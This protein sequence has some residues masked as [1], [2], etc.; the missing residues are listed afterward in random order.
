MWPYPMN[1]SANEYFS[2]PPLVQMKLLKSFV[3]F[4][5]QPFRLFETTVFVFFFPFQ[6]SH[7]AL[8]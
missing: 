1:F 2:H 6:E 3:Y 8:Q 4:L 7:N 5:D